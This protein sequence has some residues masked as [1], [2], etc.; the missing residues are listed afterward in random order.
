MSDG[1]HNAPKEIKQAGTKSERIREFVDF[2]F[3][4]LLL[5][6]I[7]EAVAR[8]EIVNPVLLP[9][10]SKVFV[11]IVHYLTPSGHFLLEKH[12]E[13][14]I[15]RLGVGFIIAAVTG[16][17]LGTAMGM[18]GPVYKFFTP[19]LSILMP[20]PSIA[21]VPIVILWLG[22]GNATPIFIVF[23]TAIF[24]ILYNTSTGV[25]SIDHRHIWAAKTM[26]A[27]NRQ[28]FFSVVLPGALAYTIIGLKV[29][30][31]SGWRALVAAEMLSA[32]TYGLGFM[33]F[34]AKEFLQIEIMYAGIVCLAVLGFIL[35]NGIFGF[36]E[37]KTLKRWGVI[38]DVS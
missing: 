25:R 37:N 32:T 23:F 29:G 16:V 2:V 18:F 1:V 10:A 14:S 35:E 38:K 22:L 21:W 30:L 5:V 15:Y 34:E 31:A 28:V 13:L 33:I 6:L 4:L 12:I 8:A 24:P 20:I 9:P 26:G 3:P 11:S 17:A 36:V 27:N 7:W 19:I